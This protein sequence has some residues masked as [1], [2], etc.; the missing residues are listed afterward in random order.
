MVISK[1]SI[2]LHKIQSDMKKRILTITAALLWGAQVFAQQLKQMEWEAYGLKFKLPAE[3]TAEV[4]DEEQFAA[5]GAHYD[6]GVQMLESE[7]MK[8]AEMA[9]ELRNIASDD[10]VQE[11]T[12]VLWKE[13]PQ[14][15]VAYL[16]GKLEDGPCVYAYLLAKDGSCAF[17]LSMICTDPAN[18]T[19]E[20]VLSTFRLE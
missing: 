14:F 11:A 15:H 2:H 19:P 1:K 9:E 3:V 7:G 18:K 13:N 12:A 10:Q 6:I 5:K 8:K 20:S 16:K 4:D 17:F